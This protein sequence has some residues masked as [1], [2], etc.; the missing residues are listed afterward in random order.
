MMSEAQMSVGRELLKGS[1]DVMLLA[2]LEGG[3]LY[4][5]QIVKEVRARSGGVLELRE[6]TLYPALHRLERAGLVES[7]WQP[8]QDG[9]DRRYY[10]LTAAGSKAA[11]AKRGEWRRFALAV[12]GVLGNAG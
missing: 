6:G 4:G 8:R 7:S 11:Q 9:A 1:L 5:Y 10:R 12:E 2:L 3:Q